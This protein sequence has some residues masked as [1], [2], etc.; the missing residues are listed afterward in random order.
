MKFPDNVLIYTND[1][2]VGCNK[3]ISACPHAGASVAVKMPDSEKSKIVVNPDF[4]VACGACFE[5]CEHDAREYSDDTLEFFNDLKKG[6]K[7]TLL[8]APAFKANYPDEYAQVLGGL[9]ELGVNRIIN[10]AFGADISTWGYINYIQKYGFT[11]GISQPCPAVVNYIEKYQ[12]EL[13]PQLFR[14]K[15]RLCVLQSTQKL[16]LKLQTSL[17]S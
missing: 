15:V 16:S 11:G 4:C 10:V 2:C 12:P 3:C 7:I 17:H 6:E 14:F 13:I 8:I 5:A 1:N 9:K